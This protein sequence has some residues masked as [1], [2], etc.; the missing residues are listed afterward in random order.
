M[1]R[2]AITVLLALAGAAQAGGLV[3]ARTLPAGSI[4]TAG[5]LILSEADHGVASPSE[6]IGLQTR[7]T[8]YEGRPILAS[9]L[10]APKLVARNQIVRLGYHRGALSIE[11]EG[12]ALAEGAA[13]DTIRVMNLA[14]RTTLSARVNEDGSL[15]VTN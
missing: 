2:L 4:L 5:D 8:V 9:Q 15:T 10:Q 14:S 7:V 3:A 6:A 12:R 11:V 1:L 13:G